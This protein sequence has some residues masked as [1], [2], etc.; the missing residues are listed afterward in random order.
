MS[1]KISYNK[2]AIQVCNSGACV[3]AS[4]QVGGVISVIAGIGLFVVGVSMLG[5]PGKK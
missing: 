4:G 5:N 2:G 1:T 3:S